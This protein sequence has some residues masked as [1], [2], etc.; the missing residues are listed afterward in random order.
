MVRA[1]LIPTSSTLSDLHSSPG[2]VPAG[3]PVGALADEVDVQRLGVL[4]VGRLETNIGH[5]L[6]PA[7]S[8]EFTAISVGP[9]DSL[10]SC[11]PAS[12]SWTVRMSAH[13]WDANASKSGGCR[14]C[15]S[16]RVQR[17]PG[18]LRR[19]QRRRRPRPRSPRDDRQRGGRGP[20]SI[21]QAWPMI[22]CA[23]FDAP[24]SCDHQRRLR[25]LRPHRLRGPDRRHGC[26]SSRITF[27]RKRTCKSVATSSGTET[28]AVRASVGA[29]GRDPIA[30]SSRCGSKTAGPEKAIAHAVDPIGVWLHDAGISTRDCAACR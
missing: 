21:R 10:L 5:R 30:R 9:S 28:P 26:N 7:T 19:P 17:G 18:R 2:V 4:A 14:S 3:L 27:S 16:C 23:S 1:A 11:H 22:A 13:R 25:R 15:S 6:S 8:I 12:K 29:P 20:T 24:T